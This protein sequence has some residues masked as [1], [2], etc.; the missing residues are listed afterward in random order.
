VLWC[1]YA[2]L[3]GVSHSFVR[4]TAGT[5]TYLEIHLGK[6]NILW[7]WHLNKILYAIYLFLLIITKTMDECLFRIISTRLHLSDT[8]RPNGANYMLNWNTGLCKHC[9]TLLRTFTVLQ[10]SLCS[11][12]VY[13]TAL[14][15]GSLCFR[16][17][18]VSHIQ[19]LLT[20]LLHLTATVPSVDI[21]SRHF[22]NIRTYFMYLSA[23]HLLNFYVWLYTSNLLL[24]FSNRL[25]F[26][27]GQ[28]SLPPLLHISFYMA[29]SFYA[30]LQH[31]GHY[32]TQ[33][34]TSN[35]SRHHQ[36]LGPISVELLSQN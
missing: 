28:V 33:Q 15:S 22:Q 16:S 24:P 1:A 25:C 3:S 5:R 26:L 11:Y 29:I 32:R 8:Q 34:N 27:Y 18:F 30:K 14:V 35:V 31:H 9:S 23:S 2:E 12:T 20:M 7:K 36:H 6:L 10:L 19:E 4:L 13:W 21:A 17:D